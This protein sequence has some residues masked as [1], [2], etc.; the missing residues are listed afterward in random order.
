MNF[1]NI[2][3]PCTLF[4]PSF[5]GHKKHVIEIVVKLS[6][7]NRNEKIKFKFWGWY[8]SHK[9]TTNPCVYS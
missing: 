8:S 7:L 1:A 9:G 4:V 5:E 2:L 3:L 6:V